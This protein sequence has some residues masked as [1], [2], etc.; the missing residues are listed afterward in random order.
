MKY[1]FVGDEKLRKS[2]EAKRKELNDKKIKQNAEKK[3]SEPRK[4]T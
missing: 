2:L 4:T 1:S 3:L